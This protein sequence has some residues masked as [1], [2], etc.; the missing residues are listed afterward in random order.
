MGGL[1]ILGETSTL[2]VNPGASDPCAIAAQ[3]P[4]PPSLSAAT[5]RTLVTT[6]LAP[7][8]PPAST[9]PVIDDSSAKTA[10]YMK[11]GL[12]AVLVVVGG[13]VVYKSTHKKAS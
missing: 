7:V 9:P 10:G 3:S 11:I 8:P 13:V 6:D 12:L 1:G 4:C 5:K 2:D